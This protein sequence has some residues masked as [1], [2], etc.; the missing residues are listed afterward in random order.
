MKNKSFLLDRDGVIIIDK[1][2]LIKKSDIFFFPGVYEALIY[3]KKKKY[4]IILVTNQSVIGRGLISE[5]DF[6]L[7]SQEINSKLSINSKV[8]LID[9][10]YFCPHHPK[11]GLNKFKKNCECRKP[12]NG[13]IEKAILENEL[14]RRKTIMIGDKLTD[15]FAAKKSKINFYYK[16]ND[17]FLSQIKKIIQNEKIQ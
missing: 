8:K 7:L 17:N 12:K 15:Y 10:V 11:K 4:K 2:H 16:K 13:L 3:L 14:D 9:K 6:E 1:K 5:K